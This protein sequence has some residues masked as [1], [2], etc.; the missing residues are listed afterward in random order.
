VVRQDTGAVETYTG[1]TMDSF[2]KRHYG[3]KTSFKNRAYEHATSLSSHIWKLKDRNI[4]YKISWDIIGRAA[5]YNTV[6]NKCRLCLLEKY[7]IMFRPAGATLN[8]ND[9]FFTSCRHKQTHLLGKVK[10]K[11]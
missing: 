10:F 11:K 2:K 5:P 1:A 4:P 9:E 3:H 8:Q 6:T 7:L